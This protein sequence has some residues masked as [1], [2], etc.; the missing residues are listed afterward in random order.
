MRFSYFFFTPYLTLSPFILFQFFRNDF[1]LFLFYFIIY[2]SCVCN[3]SW[4][5][6]VEREFLARI[7]RRDASSDT[8]G[9]NKLEE[10]PPPVLSGGSEGWGSPTT[11]VDPLQPLASRQEWGG[12][13]YGGI[14]STL[15]P[16]W[17]LHALSLCHIATALKIF[18]FTLSTHDTYLS[19]YRHTRIRVSLFFKVLCPH[20]I[21]STRKFVSYNI[22]FQ[23]SICY[24]NTFD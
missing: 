20:N 8:L 2:F 12:G 4:A 3:E 1:E 17:T 5:A 9:Y 13:D 6:F 11:P 23:S 15:R 7:S 16:P 14:R 21:S 22:K 19:I 10:L 18:S 24:N